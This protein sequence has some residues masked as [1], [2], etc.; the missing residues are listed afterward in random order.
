MYLKTIKYLWFSF[1]GGFLFFMLLLVS[2]NG[3]WF[4]L[5]GKMPD[6]KELENPYTSWASEVWSEDGVLLGKYYRENRRSINYDDLSPNLI[7]ALLATEDIRFYEHSGIDLKG[8]LS[9]FYYLMLG[10]RRGSSTITQQLA[11]NLFKSRESIYDGYFSRVA[12]LKLI[13]TKLK[14]WI[15]TVR[16]ERSY[17]KK[18][19]L[20]LYFNTVD[21]G[22]NS[23]GIKVASKT[24][25]KTTPDKL[26]V[27]QAS[28]LVGLLKAPSYYSPV[29]EPENSLRRRN[30][31]LK[32]Q[33]KYGFLTKQDFDSLKQSPLNLLYRQ[34]DSHNRGLGTYFRQEVSK[35]VSAWAKDRGI[36]IYADGIKIYTTLN[37]KMQQYAESALKSHIAKQQKIFFKHWEGRNPWVKLKN[38]RYVEIKNFLIDAMKRTDYYRSLFKQYKGNQEKIWA[39]LNKPVKMKVF[40]W[41]K[42]GFEKDTLLSP[43][44][45]LRYNKHFLHGGLLSM[46]PHTG[47]I[48]AWVGGINHKYFKYDHIRQGHRQPGST[49]K[50][51]IYAAAIE[52]KGFHPCFQVLDAPISFEIDGKIWTPRNSSRYTGNMYTLR[53]AIAQSINTVAAYL[54]QT[55]TPERAVYYA[56]NK[57]QIQS[58]L[59][60]VPSLCLGTSDVSLFELVPAYA[61]FANKGVWTE[62]IFIT[63]IE[64]KH[65]NL[66]E[67]FIPKKIESL[68]ESTAYTMTY[69]L[70]GT[71]EERNGTALGLWRYEFMRGNQI[72]AKTGTT[73]NYS[74]AWFIGATKDLVTGVWIGAEDRS[75]HFR[76]LTYGQGAR[77]AMPAFA[78]YTEMVFADSTLNYTRGVF[79][80][81]ERGLNIEL[82]CQEYQQNRPENLDDNLKDLDDIL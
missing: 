24:F 12:F 36:D 50:P 37:S 35:K 10:K 28:T 34:V 78:D 55:I 67:R 33:K 30:T 23:F 70:R 15:L 47:Y 63:H 75:V 58:P 18:E 16:I 40:A 26:D 61:I 6:L 59:E 31:V 79:Q 39:I 11:R 81:P 77:L 9:I 17:T 49:F 3:N 54:I 8:T 68:N 27:L 46:D 66:L 64:D 44:D 19:I 7:Q 20:T 57:F 74:D 38:G 22:S 72:A 21:F 71:S 13:I 48:K 65:G 62:P 45:S 42:Q 53:Q 1:I 60:A 73:S 29:Y 51:I 32:Q 14:D 2:I 25:F 80:K 4:N 69:M 82:S 41:D 43:L 56:K 76:S 5:Y 52:E